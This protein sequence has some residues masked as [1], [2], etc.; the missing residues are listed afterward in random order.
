MGKDVYYSVQDIS[1][2][3]E[4]AE[5]TVR[6]YCEEGRVPGAIL[7]GKTWLI[8]P[9]AEKPARQKRH[10]KFSK[11][12]TILSVLNYQRNANQDHNEVP[13]HTSQNGCDPKV[14]KQ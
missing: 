5:R 2:T 12:D 9:D 14:C 8:P 4:V 10:V 11:N 6:Y 3:W 13:F 1:K 7:Q